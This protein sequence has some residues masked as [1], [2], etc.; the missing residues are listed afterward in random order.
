MNGTAALF[1]E[2]IQD[3]HGLFLTKYNPITFEGTSSP[4]ATVIWSTISAVIADSQ[5]ITNGTVANTDG[6]IVIDTGAF[7][8]SSGEWTCVVP[9]VY[10]FWFGG[11]LISG[12]PIGTAT[13]FIRRNGTPITQFTMQQGTSIHSGRSFSSGTAALAE[14]GDVFDVLFTLVTTTSC[15]LV[16]NSNF[17]V[18]SV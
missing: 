12:T 2:R 1:N 4:P 14:A 7:T 5:T 15:Q 16:E 11:T 8:V 13:M 18:V 6:N 17:V 3:K 10:W 9:G